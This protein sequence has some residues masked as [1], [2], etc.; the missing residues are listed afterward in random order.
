VRP[1]KT[2]E[3]IELQFGLWTRVG[4]RTHVLGGVHTG[5]TWGIPLYGP[6]VAAM[7]PFLSNHFDHLFSFLLIFPSECRA[8]ATGDV[9]AQTATKQRQMGALTAVL[10]AAN[11]ARTA[12]HVTLQCKPSGASRCATS[13]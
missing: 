13:G 3:P 4:Q 8:V 9:D 1:A 6:F 7:R 5:A 2:A 10:S 11:D 12:E